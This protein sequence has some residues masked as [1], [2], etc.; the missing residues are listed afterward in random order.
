MSRKLYVGNLNHQIDAVELTRMFAGYG[1]QG[2]KV[3]DRLATACPH[4]AGLVEVDT[5][6][7][8]EQA[9]AALNKMLY[10]GWV[11]SVCWAEPAT[12]MFESMNI[13][14]EFEG[15]SMG[16]P[17]GRRSGDFARGVVDPHVDI[18]PADTQSAGL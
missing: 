8:G 3:F 11:L 1:V 15:H 18:A 7:H 10:R 6:A 9:M 14:E 2:V 17:P 16:E 12:R 5:E 4:A 13:P